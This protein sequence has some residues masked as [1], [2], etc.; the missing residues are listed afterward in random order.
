MIFTEFK[1]GQGL[2]NQL[3]PYVAMRAAAK[4]LGVP[5]SVINP[6]LFKGES[7][8]KIDM[9]VEGTP[10]KKFIEEEIRENGIDVRLYDRRIL[11]IEDGTEIEGIFQDETYFKGMPLGDWLKTEPIRMWDNVCVINFRGGEY[12]GVPELYLTKEYWD[13]ALGKM[14]EINH[15]MKFEVHTDDPVEASKFFPEYTIKSDIGLNW[16]SIRNAHYL[17]LS[18]SSFG[19]LPALLNTTA[20]KIIAP[21]YWARRNI[22]KWSTPQNIYDKFTY[23]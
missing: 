11:D 9:G 3:F 22:G 13:I 4:R 5:F 21:K 18:N 1:E 17:I 2:G 8:M 14:K 10:T 19:V 15:E 6:H 16:R 12:T 20:K 23:L 7:F